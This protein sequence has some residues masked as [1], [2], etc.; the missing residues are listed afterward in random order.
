M[1]SK[2]N[3]TIDSMYEKS[4]G[5]V[6]EIFDKADKTP[7]VKAKEVN[8]VKSNASAFARFG[9][10]AKEFYSGHRTD[11][12]YLLLA[13]P[14]IA[15]FLIV[16]QVQRNQSLSSQAATHQASIYFSQANWSLPPETSFDVFMNTDSTV[17]YADVEIV[18]NPSHV[19]LTSEVA[20]TPTLGRVIKLTPMAEANS[21]G[22]LSIIVALDPS[23]ISAPP[24]G[25]FKI[26]TIKLNT[27]TTSSLSTTVSFD[28][29]AMQLVSL[30][31]SVFANT[32]SGLSLELNPTPTPVPTPVPTTTPP[33]ATPTPT[34][35]ITPAP[36]ATP[37]PVV[38]A[39]PTPVPTPTSVP[40]TTIQVSGIV[41][42]ASSLASIPGATVKFQRTTAKWWQG[43]TTAKTDAYGHYGVYIPSDVYKV[44]VSKS[45]YRTTTQ[46]VTLRSNTILNFQLIK[47]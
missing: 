14:I 19:R 15:I 33:P 34:P 24:S 36:S 23:Q 10:W 20:L 8:V 31:Q 1:A 18:Y 42:N 12:K 30:D 46:T 43:A 47:K 37:T 40:S 16:R 2:L 41:T 29:T 5:E 44:T 22:K 13:I 6:E 32:V 38:T 26:A 11:F 17:G 9:K 4:K 45:G 25:I 27:K 35:V 39:A 28:N 7:E 21:T 3:Q